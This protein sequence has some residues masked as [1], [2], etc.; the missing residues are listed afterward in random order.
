MGSCQSHQPVVATV[1]KENGSKSSVLPRQGESCMKSTIG[2][3]LFDP[4]PMGVDVLTKE[5]VPDSAASQGTGMTSMESQELFDAHHDSHRGSPQE[6]E[7][8]AAIPIP[9]ALTPLEEKIDEGSMAAS[10][11]CDHIRKSSEPLKDFFRSMGASSNRIMV[12]IEVRFARSFLLF[13]L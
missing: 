11:Q 1:A 12:H 13:F 9:M 5:D 10:K 4:P 2:D 3:Y 6:E 7:E 8:F